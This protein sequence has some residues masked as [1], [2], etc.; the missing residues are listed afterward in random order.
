MLFYP[1]SKDHNYFHWHELALFAGTERGYTTICIWD[2]LA[3]G[4]AIYLNQA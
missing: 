1:Q 3:T 2:N 4:V